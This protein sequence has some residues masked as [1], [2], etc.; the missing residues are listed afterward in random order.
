MKFFTNKSIWSKIIIV[1][2]FVLVFE[3]IVAKP[4]LGA[5]V[6]D[7]IVEGGGKL[8][9]PV[10]SLVVTLGDALIGI[11]QDAI[12][13]I[14]ES[15]YPVD[16]DADFWEILGTIV[17]VAVAVVAA[18][19][20]I[21]GAIASGVGIVALIGTIASALFN[22]AIGIVIGTTVVSIAA[23]SHDAAMS[24]VSA[25]VFPDDIKVPA[26]LYLPVYS[27]SPEEIFQGKILLF[28]VDFFGEP[29]EIQYNDEEDY[30]YYTNADGEEVITSRQNIAADLS[31]TIS[32]WY[33]GI[34]NIALV[35]MMIVLLYIGIRML[36]STLASD[37]AKYRQMLQD[38]FIGVMLLFLMHYIMAFSVTLVQKL[39][40]IVST[41]VDENAYAVKFPV[42]ENGKIVKWFNENDMTYMLYGENG[43]QLATDGTTDVNEGDVAY[44]VYP[45]NLLGK[46]RLDLQ[47]DTGG[48][49]YVGYAICYL[50]L[51]FFTLYFTFVYLK[52]VLY[53]AFLTMIAPMVALTYPIDK[54]NDGSAQGFTKWF[55]EY[56]FNLLIQP[57]HLLLYY[58][59]ITSAFELAGSN[60]VYSIVAIGFMIPAEKLLRSLFGFE[61]ANTPGALNGAAGGALAMAGISKIASIATGKD[62]KSTTALGKGKSAEDS[63]NVKEVKSPFNG[64]VD[65]TSAMVSSSGLDGAA[66]PEGEEEGSPNEESTTMRGGFDEEESRI[67]NLQGSLN[68]IKAQNNTPEDME[69]INALQ[70]E[71]DGRREKLDTARQ[72]EIDNDRAKTA[73]YSE[74]SI[75][76]RL[77]EQREKEKQLGRVEKNKRRIIRGAAKVTARTAPAMRFVASASKPLLR[78][79]GATA[80]G[81]TAM[82]AGI[83]TGDPSNVLQYGA[84]GAGAGYAAGKGLSDRAYNRTNET[85]EN[86]EQM[87]TQMAQK[88]EYKDFAEAELMRIKRKEYRK[89]L[90]RN[91]F[92]KNEI[93]NLQKDGTINRYIQNDISAQDAATAELMR[94]ED[95]TITQTQA[96]MDA[97]YA[98]RVGDK[99]KGPDRKKWKEHFSGEFQEKA[100]LDKKQ[101]DDTAKKVMQR[102]DRFNKYKKKTK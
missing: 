68:Q 12:M 14:G 20:T 35:A 9:T 24:N 102:V 26:T 31:G 5:E 21:A 70:S 57:M 90:K 29:I 59:L 101:A 46:L 22:S 95:P 75:Q 38:W 7:A 37:K 83:A 71:I 3:F 63:G 30:Y 94:K 27:Y 2:I 65:E 53:M 33:V 93:D 36:L 32:R 49:N 74:D 41:S 10:L 80:V 1:L 79:A 28:N 78:V 77:A 4:T 11:A 60:I 48:F 47:F 62:S 56:I 66:L 64:D 97:K 99:Y 45:T 19:A 61:K 86:R 81:A 15:M 69:T 100:N 67:A 50:V 54:I 13:G 39:T 87:L 92:E 40:D 52:R 72:K 58:V 85:L 44:V 17:V 89:A 23:N 76:Q 82:A 51:V 42:D 8:L 55:R 18:I 96:I 43:E 84:A 16:V 98:E 25:S 88:D 91:G 73:N 6:T 34:R